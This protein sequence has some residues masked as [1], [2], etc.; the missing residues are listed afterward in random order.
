MHD[1]VPAD[2]TCSSIGYGCPD[3]PIKGLR[4]EIVKFIERDLDAE[5]E[6]HR[7]RMEAGGL[8]LDEGKARWDLMSP[9]LLTGIAKVLTFGAVKYSD[10]NWEKGIKFGR[11]FA[12]LMRHLWA[13]WGGQKT[14]EE[15]GYSHLHHAGCCLMF[16]SH[17]EDGDY[18]EFDD[19][20]GAP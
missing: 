7:E 17:F 10:R 11:C 8:K 1:P 14:D 15:T 9:V 2:W 18:A 3:H 6:G 20:P 4:G 5:M 12:A 19:R 16:L 13:W